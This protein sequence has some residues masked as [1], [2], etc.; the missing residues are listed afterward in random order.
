MVMNNDVPQH[1][2]LSKPT[3]CP[4]AVVAWRRSPKAL[5]RLELHAAPVGAGET[6]PVGSGE[7]FSCDQGTWCTP[8]PVTLGRAHQHHGS[9]ATI[10]QSAG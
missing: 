10:S 4:R 6:Q 5:H 9:V 1:F 3:S 2:V 7:N 8:S